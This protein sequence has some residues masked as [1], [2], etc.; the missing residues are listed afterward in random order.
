MP[1]KTKE[2]KRIDTAVSLAFS[3]HG[4]RA[5]INIFDIGK[6]L[7]A[8]RVAGEQGGDIDQAVKDAIARFR[9]N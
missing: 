6:I 2:Q 9:K 1:R 4:E 5:E 8:G 3:R 7:D